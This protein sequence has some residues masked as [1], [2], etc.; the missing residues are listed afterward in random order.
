MK[1]EFVTLHWRQN[2]ASLAQLLLCLTLVGSSLGSDAWVVREDGVGPVKIGMTLAKLSATLHQKLSEDKFGTD[3]CFYAHARG[4]DNV[5]FMIIDAV[6]CDVNVEAPGIETSTGI[7]VGDSEAQ[8]RRVY[9]SKIKMTALQYVDTGHYLTVVFPD[10]RYGVRF[11]TDKG[12]FTV[13]YAGKY[14]AIQLR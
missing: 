10:G 14:D 13:F 1:E 2:R 8:V 5:S 4:H 3:N 12:K 7:Q 6:C 11:V 9:G